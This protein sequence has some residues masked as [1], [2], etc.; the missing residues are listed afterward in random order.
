MQFEYHDDY[1]YINFIKKYHYASKLLK[2]VVEKIHT[3]PKISFRQN[4]EKVKGT[5]IY[6]EYY[7]CR[8]RVDMMYGGV[9]YG[10]IKNTD[11]GFTVEL[12]RYCYHPTR[13][14]RFANTFYNGDIKLYSNNM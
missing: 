14:I 6:H 10:L 4:L 7:D 13:V 12:I 1:H 11:N 9:N 5:D 3:D 2:Q 8:I